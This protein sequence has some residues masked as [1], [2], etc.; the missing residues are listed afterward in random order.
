MLPVSLDCFCFVF[1]RLVYFMLPVSLDCFCVV[2]IRLVYP[3]LSVS[4]DCF[5]FVCIRLVYPMLPV[6]LD[7]FCFVCIRHVYFMLPVSLDCFCV[8]CIRLVY[9]MLPVSLASVFSNV[10]HNPV[11]SSFMA[12]NG[13]CS[14]SNTIG[15][16]VYLS[17]AH[18]WDSCCSR[19]LVF[20]VVFYRSLFVLFLLTILLS[21]LLPF[22]ASD[23]LF[24]YFQAFAMSYK[25]NNVINHVRIYKTNTYKV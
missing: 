5:C 16:T 6:S 12:Y 19:S 8:V 14:K 17:G 1:I 22:S 15:T 23:Y 11:L 18:E 3:M 25:N 9:P 10:F 13:V 24:W 2:C 21:R 20:C 4:L 7:C